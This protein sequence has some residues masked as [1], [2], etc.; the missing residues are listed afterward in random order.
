M[1]LDLDGELVGVELISPAALAQ[2]EG[3]LF[4]GAESAANALL[5]TSYD[6]QAD[7]MYVRASRGRLAHQRTADASVV[8]SPSGLVLEIAVTDDPS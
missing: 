8:I 5:T 2:I 3:I 6:P 7:A 4:D 1:D